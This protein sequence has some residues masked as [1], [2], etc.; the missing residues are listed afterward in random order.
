MQSVNT[1]AFLLRY[2]FAFQF[3]SDSIA[4]NLHQSNRF[5]AE[6]FAPI[7]VQHTPTVES[8]HWLL[9]HVMYFKL[10][11]KR[12][13]DWVSHWGFDASFRRCCL[14]KMC[15]FVKDWKNDLIQHPN[16][17]KK[18]LL[19]VKE[20]KTSLQAISMSALQSSLFRMFLIAAPSP[21]QG[22]HLGYVY[23]LYWKKNVHFCSENFCTL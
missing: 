11:I 17:M 10:T 18:N 22:A 19:L 3:N 8:Q 21:Q 15:L 12:H 5:Y 6:T 20:K 16:C 4:L 9:I 14:R 13:L 7:Q 2:S 23:H 1:T